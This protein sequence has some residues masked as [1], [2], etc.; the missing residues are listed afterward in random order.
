MSMM[1]MTT[2]FLLTTLSLLIAEIL[3]T[4]KQRATRATTIQQQGFRRPFQGNSRSYTPQPSVFK[5]VQACRLPGLKR[6]Q[7][8]R[9]PFQGNSRSYTPQPSVFKGVQACRWPGLKPFQHF[10][11]ISIALDRFGLR[12]STHLTPTASTK[13]Q[14]IAGSS[15]GPLI[16]TPGRP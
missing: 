14:D 4:K 11:Q 5:G 1:F 3:D 9:R 2:P 16:P 7:R 8:S 13:L 15:N 6:F 12:S 10:L